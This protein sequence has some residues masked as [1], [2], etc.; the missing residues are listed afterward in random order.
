VAQLQLPVLQP[1]LLKEGDHVTVA[2][3]SPH[4]RRQQVPRGSP[5]QAVLCKKTISSTEDCWNRNT[6]GEP[7]PENS[8]RFQNQPSLKYLR[9]N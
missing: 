4:R 9:K 3:G 5:R 8:S 6:G 7:D 2:G 1:I